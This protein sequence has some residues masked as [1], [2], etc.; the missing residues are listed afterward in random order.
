MLKLVGFVTVVWFLFYVG[1]M[2]IAAAW[3][4]VALLWIAGQ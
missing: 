3:G 4:A 1:L 2:Q